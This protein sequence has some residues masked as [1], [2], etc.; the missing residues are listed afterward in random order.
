M[1]IIGI[2]DI[3]ICACFILIFSFTCLGTAGEK[4]CWH[5]HASQPIIYPLQTS[6]SKLCH[7]NQQSRKFSNYLITVNQLFFLDNFVFKLIGQLNWFAATNFHD[8]DVDYV[9]YVEKN[10]LE[11]FEDLIVARSIRDIEAISQTSFARKL[12]K[13]G[14]ITVLFGLDVE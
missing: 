12:M 7:E 3:N 9:D 11:A 4:F 1:E 13:V 5:N 2:L 10:I 6:Y 8:Q 14:L